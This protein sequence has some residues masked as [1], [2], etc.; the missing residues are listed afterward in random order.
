VGLKVKI[1]IFIKKSSD[2]NQKAPPSVAEATFGGHSPPESCE[3]D[4]R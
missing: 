3:G 1:R 4:I 2:F